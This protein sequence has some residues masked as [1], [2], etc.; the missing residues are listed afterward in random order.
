[1]NNYTPGPWRTDEDS[2]DQPYQEIAIIGADNN[3]VAVVWQDDACHDRNAEQQANA[4]LIASAPKMQEAILGY[5]AALSQAEADAET[6]RRERDRAESEIIML[7][8]LLA[9]RD[10]LIR[11]TRMAIGDCMR[12]MDPPDGGNVDLPEMVGRMSDAL[13]KEE[14]PIENNVKTEP[15]LMQCETCAGEGVADSSP[16]VLAPYTCPDCHGTGVD[17]G[18]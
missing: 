14:A 9:N 8:E 18:E 17:R 15:P 4:Q 2:H 16:G 6:V 7:R 1:M 3:L 5:R 12:W 11:D 13:T 10:K